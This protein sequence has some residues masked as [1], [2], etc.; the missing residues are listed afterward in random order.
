MIKSMVISVS[1]VSVLT[2]ISLQ[3]FLGNEAGDASA[4][5]HERDQGGARQAFDL[6]VPAGKRLHETEHPGDARLHL[7]RRASVGFS[8]GAELAQQGESRVDLALLAL[9]D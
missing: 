6:V 7:G 2:E 4:Q 3:I 1:A 9:L 5:L 8:F